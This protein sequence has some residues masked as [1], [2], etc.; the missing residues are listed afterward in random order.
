MGEYKYR[1]H[2]ELCKNSKSTVYDLAVNVWTH[3][4]TRLNED[5]LWC[6]CGKRIKEQC[7]VRNKFNH[8][9]LII[10]NV[11][12]NKFFNRNLNFY[13][14]GLKSCIN[15]ET[16]NK[17]FIQLAYGCNIINNYEYTFMIDMFR[18]KKYSDKQRHLKE[19]IVNKLSK[20]TEFKELENEK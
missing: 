1:F 6:I 3:T 7:I 2:S 8:K 15:Q 10:G 12:I 18:K 4:L 14:D 16:P 19:S 20:F 5:W 11:C 17:K 13:F 9:E